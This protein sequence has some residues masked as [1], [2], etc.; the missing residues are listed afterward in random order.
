MHA[1]VGHSKKSSFP[2]P[3][4]AMIKVCARK[5]ARR[6]ALLKTP[7]FLA[8]LWKNKGVEKWLLGLE[9]DNSSQLTKPNNKRGSQTQMK[10]VE[11]PST[12]EFCTQ[13]EF[14]Y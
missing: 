14:K 3:G 8:F 11:D 13:T 6:E 10:K 12:L 2:F 1:A 7:F 5:P 4:K 9:K